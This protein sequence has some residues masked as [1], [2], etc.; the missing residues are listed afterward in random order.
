MPRPE[1]S[2]PALAIPGGLVLALLR[3]KWRLGTILAIIFVTTVAG[4]AIGYGGLLAAMMALP[5]ASTIGLAEALAR[6][7]GLLAALALG[8]FAGAIGGGW[9][10]FRIY[11]P[12][13]AAWRPAPQWP[14]PPAPPPSVR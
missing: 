8:G 12:R 14:R 9:L 3:L 7:A 4:A 1:T 10:M 2:R 5:H 11:A 13:L 6:A